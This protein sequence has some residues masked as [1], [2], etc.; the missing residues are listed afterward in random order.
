LVSTEIP[1]ID[2]TIKKDI[3]DKLYWYNIEDGQY[4]Y[5][6]QIDEGYY[7]SKSLLDKIKEKINQVKR[8]TSKDTFIVYNY[9]EIL[10][11]SNIQKITFLPYNLTKL[12]NKLSARLEVIDFNTYVILNVNHE[13]NLVEKNDIIE[14]KNSTAVTYIKNTNEGVQ[15]FEISN[16]YINKSHI[17]YSVNF[18]NNTYD[19]LLGKVEEITKTLISDNKEKTGGEN[20]LVKSKTQVIFL[21]D[22]KDTI[23]DIIGFKNVGDSFSITNFSSIVTNK[24]PYIYSNNLNSVGIEFDYSSGFF[25]LSGK[26]NYI[27]MYL[28][29]IEFVYS[30]NNIPSAFAKIALAGSPGD[31]LFDTFIS[32]PQYIY[33]KIFPISSLTQ[34]TV[35]FLYPDGSRINFRNINHSFT[36]KI[37]E[38]QEKNDNTNLNSHTISVSD[39]Y[40]KA[41]L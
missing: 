21:F 13:N 40:K 36:L 2:L 18:D 10:L 41:H 22:K 6:V 20:I 5:S 29:D 33:S 39:E 35:K 15:I 3:N 8:I 9:F 27:L 37:T 19:I 25:N 23:G 4:L 1:Y 30:N 7:S 32:Q 14:I 24:D 26:F 16:D 34:I 28:N 11:E 17:V 31:I 38:E 12:S